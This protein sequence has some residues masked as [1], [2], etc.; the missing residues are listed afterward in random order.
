MNGDL[1]SLE[2]Q[3][4]GQLE[5]LVN[6][7]GAEFTSVEDML[8]PTQKQ[9]RNFSDHGF[10]D[11]TLYYRKPEKYWN[12]VGLLVPK[13]LDL[14]RSAPVHVFFLGGGFVSI[15]SSGLPSNLS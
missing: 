10:D 8:T 5:G 6:C 9:M 2:K 14:K 4:K 1:D 15:L 7:L 12:E 3:Y 13:G 11:Y